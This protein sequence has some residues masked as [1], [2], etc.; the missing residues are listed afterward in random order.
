M[1]D[2]VLSKEEMDA[3]LDGDADDPSASSNDISDPEQTATAST[4]GANFVDGDSELTA[5]DFEHQDIIIRGQ[6]PVLERIYD[7]MLLNLADP[8]FNLFSREIELEQE[9]FSIIK[10]REFLATLEDPLIINIYRLD[11]LRS[12][13]LVIFNSEAI[14]ELVENY[15]GGHSDETDNNDE[16]RELTQTEIRTVDMVSNKI[17]EKLE[18]SWQQIEKIKIEKS[19]TETSIQ[20]LNIYGAAD[21][22]VT[23]KFKLSFGNEKSAFYIVMP[24]IMIEPIKEQLELGAAQSDQEFDPN[25]IKSLKKELL[26]VNINVS[27]EIFTNKLRLSE[28]QKWQVGDFIPLEMTET[29][30]MKVENQPFF[31]VKIGTS[32]EKL[33]LQIVKKIEY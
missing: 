12:K 23:S 17:I 5:L 24:Y 33:S 8:L 20:M 13:A 28:V 27:A 16:L 30:P 26:N 15:Y 7:R 10:C 19:R 21:L 22:L 18:E 9:A 29:I 1:D 32:N 3:L 2:S 14:F 31:S 4:S 6:F 25:W 11:P